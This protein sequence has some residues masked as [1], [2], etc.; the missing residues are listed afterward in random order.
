MK[1]ILLMLIMVVGFVYAKSFTFT[2]IPD[3]DETQLKERF[4][5]LAVYLTKELNVDVKFV[6]VKSY[7]ASIAAFRNNQVQLAWFGGLSGVK[8]RL[9]VPGSVAIAQGYEDPNFHSFIIA[10][11]ST[12]LEKSETIPAGIEGKTF[13]F[14]SKGSTSGRLMPEYFITEQFKKSPNDLFKKVGFSGNHSKTVELVQS[15]AYE[16]GAVNYKVWKRELKSGKIDPSKVKIIYQTPGYPDY[17][18]TARGDLDKQFGAGF[19]KKLQAAILNI[20]DEKILNAFPRTG[21]IEAKNEDFKPVLDTARKLGL[22][23]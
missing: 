16:V 1:K 2:A 12:G 3:Q 15:G 22:V 23:D 17:N 21:F 4:S 20:K 11:T 19:T 13:T 5:K 10:N 6:P 7:S 14:G 9:V 18:F 8:A